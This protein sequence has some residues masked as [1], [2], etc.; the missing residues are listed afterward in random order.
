MKHTKMFF[1]LVV[2]AAAVLAF[3]CNQAATP[4]SSNTTQNGGNNGS[5]T[6][7]GSSGGF[8]MNA[9]Q[10]AAYESWIAGA[11]QQAATREIPASEVSQAV[12]GSNTGFASLGFKVVDTKAD[13]PIAQG[14][15]ADALKARFKAEA[16]SGGNTGGN[17]GGTEDPQ[18]QA[19][20]E[21]GYNAFIDSLV[22]GATISDIPSVGVQQILQAQNTAFGTY[23]YKITDSQNGA[24]INQGTTAEQLKERFKLEK[25]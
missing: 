5:D 11:V 18:I 6:G 17:T 23:G 22:Q 25:K 14:T 3:G 7:G 15:T 1:A 19:I 12:Q 2:L 16:V 13:Q 20:I 8:T 9:A 4:S 21:Q 24:Q 10:K